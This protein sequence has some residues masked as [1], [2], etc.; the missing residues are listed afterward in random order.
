MLAI[1]RH[2]PFWDRPWDRGVADGNSSF[3]YGEPVRVWNRL[4]FRHVLGMPFLGVLPTR[5]V[6][7][8][9]YAH[10]PP[11]FA[12][13]TGVGIRLLGFS[14]R[15]FR[16][17]PAA[18]CAVSGAVLVVLLARR[19]GLRVAT[20]AAVLWLSVPMT[21]IYGAMCNPE[22]ATCCFV[23]ITV[24]L[25]V[26]LRHRR[27]FAYVPVLLAHV[28]ATWMDWEGHFTV[29]ALLVYECL[30]P[31]GDR[32]IGRVVALG[33]MGL[34]AAAAVFAV[35]GFWADVAFDAKEALV[36]GRSFT[37]RFDLAMT[38]SYVLSGV[39]NALW[40]V[41]GLGEIRST[42]APAAWA[43]NQGA[44]VLEMHTIPVI[45]AAVAGVLCRVVS[46]GV[47]WCRVVSRGVAWCRVV[48]RGVAWCRVVSRG[49]AWCRVV[50][51]GVAWCRVVRPRTTRFPSGSH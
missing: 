45:L 13:T 44:T 3:Y 25:H 28:V 17:I 26:E 40:T 4:G 50:S 38:G 23:L 31:R 41:R 2:V 51:R 21:F 16:Q 32:R 29:P 33:V 9:L 19:G 37:P 43:L 30:R 14:E 48:S 22:A 12:W 18:F 11:G 15:S 27:A 49:V 8:V 42:L 34:I 47:A 10:H 36:A 24:L 46:R 7:G 5:P 39:K 35:H 6:I 20:V 1:V